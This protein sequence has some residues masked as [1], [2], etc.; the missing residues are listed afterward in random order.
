[1]E[2]LIRQQPVRLRHIGEHDGLQF[3]TDSRNRHVL[4]VSEGT[5]NE[6]GSLIE[7]ELSRQPNRLFRATASVSRDQHQS[8][9]K[10][11]A[12]SVDLLNCQFRPILDR[13]SRDCARPRQQSKEP[14]YDLSFVRHCCCSLT[15]I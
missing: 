6:L 5:L 8:L 10:H 12:S 11:T 15:F 9:P 14:Y 7:H 13:P 1:M 2:E 4:S 3:L